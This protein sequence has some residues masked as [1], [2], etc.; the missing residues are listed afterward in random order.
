MT[1]EEVQKLDHGLYRIF[2]KDGSTSLAAIGSNKKG[3]RWLAPTNWVTVSSFDRHVVD[4]S[5]IEKVVLLARQGE[6]M[7]P[8]TQ[9]VRN[10]NYPPIPVSPM[11][12]AINGH[13]CLCLNGP[14]D[15][16]N[17]WRLDKVIMWQRFIVA[18]TAEVEWLKIAEEEKNRRRQII[19]GSYRESIDKENECRS[20]AKLWREWG[21]TFVELK[22]SEKQKRKI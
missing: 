6:N 4:W 10:M 9:F 14:D 21:N 13:W 11:F 22:I 16:D 2:W 1:N 8:F 7:I 12:I 17:I 20:N 3:K 5:F 19:A 18:C 15:E